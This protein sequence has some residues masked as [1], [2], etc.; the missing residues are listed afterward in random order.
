MSEIFELEAQVRETRGTATNRRL[1]RIENNIPAVIYG[2][3][4]PVT[5]ITLSHNI[6]KRALENEAFFSHILTVNVGKKKEQVILKAVQRHPYKTN[7]LHMDFLRIKAN[8]KLTMN[9][10]LHFIN[11]EKSPGVRGGGV[12]THHFNEVEVSCLPKDLPQYIEIDLAT[13][14]LNEGIHL[15]ALKLPSGVELTDLQGDEPQDAAV[16]HIH[17]PRVEEEPEVAAAPP[18][19]IIGTEEAKTE[20]EENSGESTEDKK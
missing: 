13:L 11:E 18:E 16:V 20:G 1:R 10:P 7:V 2:A 15:S 12:V 14:E 4:E 9:I 3:D 19:T 8:E 17:P 5:A 6:V